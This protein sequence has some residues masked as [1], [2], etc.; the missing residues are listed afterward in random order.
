MR[1][2]LC[3]AYESAT[4]AA[5]WDEWPKWR[6]HIADGVFWKSGGKRNVQS[7]ALQGECRHR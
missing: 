2:V 6:A 1:A 5:L 4:H 3:C 7:A